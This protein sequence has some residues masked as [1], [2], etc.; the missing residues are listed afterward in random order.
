MN[1]MNEAV[2]GIENRPSNPQV[3]PSPCKLA[4]L[5]YME[6]DRWHRHTV[7]T[8]LS[9][10]V[11][12]AP[13]P[14]PVPSR[15][16]VLTP[17]SERLSRRYLPDHRKMRHCMLSTT[18]QLGV[19]NAVS[20]TMPEA[21]NYHRKNTTV[22]YQGGQVRCSGSSAVMRLDLPNSPVVMCVRR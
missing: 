7:R 6:Y 21:H 4:K 18:N 13:I 22:S 3:V 5:T 12:I 16:S 15:A 9:H 20:G 10:G 11:D 17:T 14:V 19:Y 8:D 2:L 1:L